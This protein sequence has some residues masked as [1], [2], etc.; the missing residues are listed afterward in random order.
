MYYELDCVTPTDKYP[1][2]I[3]KNPANGARSMTN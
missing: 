2:Q 3:K 1:F